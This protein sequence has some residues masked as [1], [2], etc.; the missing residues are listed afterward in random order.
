MGVVWQEKKNRNVSD[1]N[2]NAFCAIGLL[3]CLLK[4]LARFILN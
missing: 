1:E 4:V 3:V 2:V